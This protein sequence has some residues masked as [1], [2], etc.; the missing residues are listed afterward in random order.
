MK[1]RSG[2]RLSQQGAPRQ[3]NEHLAND[4]RYGRVLVH[5]SKL[6]AQKLFPEV[7]VTTPLAIGVVGALDGSQGNIDTSR[8]G[9]R[10]GPV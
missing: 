8:R 5:V 3:H 2:G 1:E 4:P 7:I 10:A 6:A 9:I